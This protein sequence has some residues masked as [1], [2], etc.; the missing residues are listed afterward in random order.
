MGAL[1]TV[2]HVHTNY[3][4]DSNAAPADVL[5]TARAQG[6]HVVA[7]TD[8]DE[9]DGAREAAALGRDVQV[10]IGEEISSADGHLIGL[11]LRERIP[12]GLPGEETAR[13]I[14]EQ[15]GLVFAPHPYT[16]LCEASL[17]ERA[18]L[19]LLPWLDA[20]EVCNA[21]DPLAWE[22]RWAERFASA[23]GVTPYCGAD[24]H[25]RGYLAGCF[26][27]L[28]GFDSPNAFLAALGRAQLVRGWFGWGYVAQMGARHV[29]DKLMP[30]PLPGYGVN[31]RRRIPG[32]A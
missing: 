32:G 10:I 22:N 9:I 8:H 14:R 29:W 5:E 28:S 16:I 25:L 2:I 13:R 12:P 17:G 21:Q 3:S 24:A 11:F 31:R 1:K 15:G 4:H 23:H 18:M 26:Q 30:R 27:V 20:V 6:V 19:R 7:I